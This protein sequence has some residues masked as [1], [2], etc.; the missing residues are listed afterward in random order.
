MSN[1]RLTE[2]STPP[3]IPT[4]IFMLLRLFIFLFNNTLIIFKNNKIKKHSPFPGECFY[5]LLNVVHSIKNVGA[6]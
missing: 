3:D 5:N 1:K 6:Q 2:E 4:A